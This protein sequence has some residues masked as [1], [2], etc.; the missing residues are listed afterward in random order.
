[1]FRRLCLTT[2]RRRGSCS[3]W[4]R[5]GVSPSVIT[6]PCVYTYRLRNYLRRDGGRALRTTLPAPWSIH[7]E[8]RRSKWNVELRTDSNTL[9]VWIRDAFAGSRVD[10]CFVHSGSCAATVTLKKKVKCKSVALVSHG[11]VKEKRGKRRVQS[12]FLSQWKF[13]GPVLTDSVAQVWWFP[14][15]IAKILTYA[16]RCK[17]RWPIVSRHINP[18][19]A[20]VRYLQEDSRLLNMLDM[21][22]EILRRFAST[23]RNGDSSCRLA[24]DSFCCTPD[25]L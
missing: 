3:K 2:V 10:L 14:E 22:E 18:P 12:L 13:L 17:D 21:L 19:I 4:A 6:L 20:V 23:R 8:G 24:G 9:L 15:L 1:M 25:I 11:T 7:R 5:G 16:F